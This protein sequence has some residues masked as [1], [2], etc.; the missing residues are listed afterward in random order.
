MRHEEVECIGQSSEIDF[1]ATS[2]APPKRWR[3]WTSGVSIARPWS[4]KSREAQRRLELEAI[5]EA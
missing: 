4:C 5:V 2:F 3:R 1:I